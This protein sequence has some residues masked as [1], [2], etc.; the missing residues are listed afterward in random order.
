MKSMNDDVH[1]DIDDTFVMGLHYLTNDE[2]TVKVM[3]TKENKQIC[4]LD[5]VS[6][7]LKIMGL[8]VIMR[9]LIFLKLEKLPIHPTKTSHSKPDWNKLSAVLNCSSF[10]SIIKMLELNTNT[11]YVCC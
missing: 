10:E 3:V 9:W 5:F 4:Y 2:T 7:T 1:A 8:K 6:N 11:N